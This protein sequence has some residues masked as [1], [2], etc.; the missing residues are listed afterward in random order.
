MLSGGATSGSSRNANTPEAITA[1]GFGKGGNPE[2]TTTAL[3]VPVGPAVTVGVASGISGVSVGG[4][5]V[6]VGDGVNVGVGEDIG[7]IVG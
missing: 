1:G 3:G 7:G 2:S 6:G 5:A 4:P